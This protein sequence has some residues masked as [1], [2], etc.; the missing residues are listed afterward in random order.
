MSCLMKKTR[1]QYTCGKMAKRYYYSVAGDRY[2][3]NTPDTHYFGLEVRGMCTAVL[4]N[5]SQIGK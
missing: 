4:Q 5:W 3:P 1:T 2:A